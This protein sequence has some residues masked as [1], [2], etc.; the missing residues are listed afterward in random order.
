[1]EFTS[2]HRNMA[3]EDAAER[4]G[5][6]EKEI[7]RLMEIGGEAGGLHAVEAVYEGR[8]RGIRITTAS[9]RKYLLERDRL[10]A[11]QKQGGSASG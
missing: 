5:V 9:V 3:I 6:S 7:E 1:M 8:A 4:L 11:E 2:D 10:R